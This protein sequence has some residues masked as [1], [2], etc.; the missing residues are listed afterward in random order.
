MTSTQYFPAS[1]LCHARFARIYDK[2][3]KLPYCRTDNIGKVII[4]F[5]SF[6]NLNTFSTFC[7]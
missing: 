4:N 2:N 3:I 6:I 7:C 1:R 5:V